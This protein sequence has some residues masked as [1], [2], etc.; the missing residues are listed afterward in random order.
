MI[1]GQSPKRILV[2]RGVSNTGKT[3]LFA[4]LMAYARHLE[5]PAALVDFKGCPS[6]DDQ[7]QTLRLDLGPEILHHAD[8]ASGT[9]RFYHLISD[10]QK[11]RAPLLLIFDTY[12]Q[13]SEDAHKWLESQLLPRLDRAPSVVVLLGGQRIPEYNKYSWRT[14]TPLHRTNRDPLHKL[15]KIMGSDSIN[16]MKQSTPSLVHCKVGE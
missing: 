3:V 4:E 10:L 7:F 13:A 15:C 1:T 2:V 11:I 14:L 16:R 12:E 5:L 6:L 9:A 8:A